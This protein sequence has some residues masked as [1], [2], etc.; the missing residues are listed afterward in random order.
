[1]ADADQDSSP[2]GMSRRA[3]LTLAAGAAAYVAPHTAA[4]APRTNDMVLMD[5]TTLGSA[6]RSRKASASK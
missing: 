6:I 3:V 2:A 1:M 5:A 4:A